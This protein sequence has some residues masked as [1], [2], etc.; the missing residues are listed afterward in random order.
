MLQSVALFLIIVICGASKLDS[1]C[2]IDINATKTTARCVAIPR[3]LSKNIVRLVIDYSNNKEVHIKRF[4]L[5][6]EECTSIEEIDLSF[7]QFRTIETR[8]FECFRNLKILRLSHNNIFH[9]KSRDLEGLEHLEQ[10]WL[11][12]NQ[13]AIFPTVALKPLISLQE[14]YISANKI[15]FFNYSDVISLGSLPIRVFMFEHNDF[16]CGCWLSYLNLW[17]SSRGIAHSAGA[18]CYK[19]DSE[20]KYRA[21]SELSAYRFG[22]N[23]Q[24]ASVRIKAIEANSCNGITL[25]WIAEPILKNFTFEVRVSDY[26]AAMFTGGK[27]IQKYTQENRLSIGGL[28]PE[29]LYLVQV[30]VIEGNVTLTGSEPLYFELSMFSLTTSEATK[31]L[32]CYSTLILIETF[33]PYGVACNIFLML[34]LPIIFIICKLRHKRTLSP[35]RDEPYAA[36]G[37]KGSLAK[38]HISLAAYSRNASFDESDF[39]IISSACGLRNK[40]MS[41]SDLRVIPQKHMSNLKVMLHGK[42]GTMFS[43]EACLS[44]TKSLHSP[45]TVVEFSQR[46]LFERIGSRLLPLCSLKHPNLLCILGVVDSPRCVSIIYEYIEVYADLK[47]R[48]CQIKCNDCKQ[49]PNGVAS[50]T[51]IASQIACGLSYLGEKEFYHGDISARNILLSSNLQA[52][53]TYIGASMDMYPGD[54]FYTGGRKLPIRWMSPE[55]IS[56]RTSSCSKECDIWSFGILLWELYSYGQQPYRGYNDTEV[57]EL[58]VPNGCKLKMPKECPKDMW[59]LMKKCWIYEPSHRISIMSLQRKILTDVWDVSVNVLDDTSFLDNTSDQEQQTSA[60]FEVQMIKAEQ[61][62]WV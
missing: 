9:L 15:S 51:L 24:L 59:K 8:A 37:Y 6:K 2:N 42:F 13:L 3:S 44:P 28:S 14:L 31:L 18:I 45:V 60:N 48:L 5:P 30:Q 52:K 49:L 7:N 34:L 32:P 39:A 41:S 23:N 35:T 1:N 40:L 21:T 29:I 43:G 10:L 54:Y 17:L 53:I 20:N 16:E 56:F 33:I 38:K 47:Q 61:T 46:R 25:N 55:S 57:C 36:Y 26:M 11:D 12:H 19:K 62:N 50:L 22:C 4:K 58:I 27:P